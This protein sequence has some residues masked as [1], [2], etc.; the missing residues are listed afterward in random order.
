MTSYI[1]YNTRKNRPQLKIKK[2]KNWQN[3]KRH[4]TLNGVSFCFSASDT[5]KEVSEGSKATHSDQ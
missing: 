5:S 4:P 1:Y 2:H 3:K